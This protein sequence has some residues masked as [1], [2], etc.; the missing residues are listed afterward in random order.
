[1]I[2]SRDYLLDILRAITSRLDI[3]EVLKL[4]TQAAV[5]VMSGSAGLITLIEADGELR[6][7]DAV[8]L[9]KAM[10]DTLTTGLAR[11]RMEEENLS[12]KQAVYAVLRDNLHGLELDPRCTLIGAF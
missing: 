4:V 1:M 10:L 3:A 7:R 11:L 2:E 6:L 12:A 8:G 9:P 5:D